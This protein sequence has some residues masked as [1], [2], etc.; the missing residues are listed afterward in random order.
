[1]KQNQYADLTS[2][3]ED[4]LDLEKKYFQLFYDLF[5][6]DE[7]RC[8]LLKIENYLS[9][10]QNYRRIKDLYDKKNIIDVGLERLIRKH[11]YSSQEY[12][13]MIDIYPSPVSADIAFQTNE[14]I[15]NL[16]SKTIDSKGNRT[17]WNQLQF[18]KNQSSFKNKFPG[19]SEFYAGC[20]V[21]CSLPVEEGNKPLLTYFLSLKYT[22]DG[23]CFQI[24]RDNKSSNMHLTVLPNGHLSSLFGKDLIINCK[25]Y[26][27]KK[28]N[29]D[30]MNR[31]HLHDKDI[32]FPSSNS[33]ITSLNKMKEK[34]IKNFAKSEFKS[35]NKFKKEVQKTGFIFPEN[36]DSI[37]VFSRWGFIDNSDGNAWLP[38]QIGSKNKEVVFKSLISGHTLR[39]SFSDLTDRFDSEEEEWKGH[40]E[41]S[42]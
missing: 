34:K 26:N 2:T 1:M 29:A 35:F 25:N 17:D 23:N 13:E 33:V 12:L 20:D 3:Q 27:Y 31:Y 6:N 14:A 36:I 8:D 38:V 37:N 42:I 30:N 32:C 39:A 9:A 41:W 10:P 28:D 19:K 11:I 16:D 7:F 40:L 5:T 22:D 18:E 21:K 15:I 24:F 4:I